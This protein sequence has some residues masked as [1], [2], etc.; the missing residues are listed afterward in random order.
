MERFVSIWQVTLAK[1]ADILDIRG[2]VDGGAKDKS[3]ISE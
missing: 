3:Q 2:E 1:F